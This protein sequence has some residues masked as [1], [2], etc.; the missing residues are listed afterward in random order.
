MVDRE[1]R[2]VEIPEALRSDWDPPVSP[3]PE[4]LAAGKERLAKARPLILNKVIM[5][6]GQ[7]ITIATNSFAVVVPSWVMDESILERFQFPEGV[8]NPSSWVT[9]EHG[10]VYPC[11]H[12]AE[13]IGTF[14]RNLSQGTGSW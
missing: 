13:V 5:E 11:W 14:M 8:P 2:L 1:A 7:G 4:Q 3:T 9:D 10:V 12:E 6:L